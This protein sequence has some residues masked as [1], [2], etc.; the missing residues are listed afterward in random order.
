MSE[1]GGFTVFFQMQDLGHTGLMWG[2]KTRI[3]T[4]ERKGFLL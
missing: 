1:K 3:R 2:G 4:V